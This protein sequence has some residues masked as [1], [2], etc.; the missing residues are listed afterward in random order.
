MFQRHSIFTSSLRNL[1]PILLI[2]IIYCSILMNL[3][4][5]LTVN[6]PF[7]VYSSLNFPL[8]FSLTHLYFSYL[9]FISNYY[10]LQIVYE[11]YLEM[12]FFIFHFQEIVWYWMEALV[13][14]YYE[15]SYDGLK[16]LEEDLTGPIHVLMSLQVSV[17]FLDPKWNIMKESW[18]IV[19]RCSLKHYS[20]ILCL[21]FI[22]CPH[23][24]LLIWVH[25]FHQRNDEIRFLVQLL[26]EKEF[27]ELPWKAALVLS[28]FLLEI[29][30]N[31]RTVQL[32]YN[33]RTT[34]QLNLCREFRR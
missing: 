23:Y 15:A 5:P 16:C 10:S 4:I 19:H 32:G 18:G 30:D 7:T 28:H 8:S 33:Q 20:E 26:L 3:K 12:S 14:K 22:Y 21:E 31:L 11:S 34:Y 17:S 1:N 27:Q 25:S 13:L 24:Q 2:F 6:S 29:W 9:R